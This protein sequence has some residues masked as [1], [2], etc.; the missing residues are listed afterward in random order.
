LGQR[1]IFNSQSTV[2]LVLTGNFSGL[3]LFD[4]PTRFARPFSIRACAA[5]PAQLPVPKRPGVSAK[6]T[7][8]VRVSLAF[9]VFGLPSP[10]AAQNHK[11]Y[12]EIN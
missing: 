3:P 5:S 11:T 6:S 1:V 2:T 12:S 9:C 7:R 4:F 10:L 8:L